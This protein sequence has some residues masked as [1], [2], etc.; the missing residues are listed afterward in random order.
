M[1]HD[2]K[3]WPVYFRP[4]KAGLKTFEC[5]RNDRNFVAGDFIHVREYVPHAN[6]YTGDTC[7]FRITY[8]MNGGNSDVPGLASGWAVLGIARV[9]SV[10]E[11]APHPPAPGEAPLIGYAIEATVIE[12]TPV[13]LI[14]EDV[15]GERH[16]ITG[17]GY[18]PEII[19]GAQGRLTMRK[20][21]WRFVKRGE[22]DPTCQHEFDPVT[23]QCA[24]CQGDMKLA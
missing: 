13:M 8:V 10:K 5:R 7:D 16:S 20:D 3:A 9:E 22:L 14:L 19:A 2:L 1:T 4:L 15:R 18:R 12:T 23:Y 6:E 17:P 11:P 24:H 21:G